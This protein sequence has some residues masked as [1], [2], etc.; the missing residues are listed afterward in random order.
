MCGFAGVLDRGA[1]PATGAEAMAR[2]LEHRGPDGDGA[3]SDGP[4]S[5]AHRRLAILDP[6]EAAHQPMTSGSLVLAYNGEI[7]NFRELASELGTRGHA[8]R[9]KGDTEVLLAAYR[10]WGPECL[11][12][13]NGMF[14]FAV[15]DGA[16]RELFLARDRF[17][18]K[19]LYWT[20]DGDRFL[21]ASEVKALL[22]AGLPRRVD[23]KALVEYFTF[24]NIFTDRTLFEGVHLLPPG[25]CL[26]LSPERMTRWRWWDL[27]F[28]SDESRAE[29]DWEADVRDVLSAAV[30]RH[31]VSDAPL[32][33]YLSG[34]M[35]SASIVALASRKMPGLDTF[36]GGFDMSSVSGLELV[37][38]ER[39]EAALV[40]S[41]AGAHRHE[42]VMHSGDMGR[43]M[44]RL[45]WN[46]EDPRAG[47]CYQNLYVADLAAR[48]VK[49]ALAGT[50]GD[51]I[52]AGY[53]WR[54]AL[55]EDAHDSATF[56]ERYFA[57]W[58][59]VVPVADH[60]AFFTPQIL[61]GAADHAPFDIYRE[62]VAPGDGYDP[63]QRALY[64]ETKTFLHAL[65]VIEDKISMSAGLEVRLPFLDQELV[66]LVSRMP[67]RFKFKNGQGKSVLRRAMRDVLPA[68]IVDKPK[69]GFTPPEGSWHRGESMAYVRDVLLDERTLGRGMILP[70]AIRTAVEEHVGGTR[71]HR[72]LIWSLLVFEW[73]NRVF[74]DRSDEPAA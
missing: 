6:S 31:L 16:R 58:N 74:I 24:Q 7:Y 11:S 48:S 60:A 9:S 18:M 62:V 35:D 33:S 5:V 68:E 49:V 63:V 41:A 59:R 13:L 21:F 56:D 25:T 3:F 54:Y 52:F 45:T 70:D 36:T 73:W 46:V 50:G 40:A 38:D 55:I 20:L 69:Q 66:S 65:L 39:A 61:D 43:V 1:E 15:W 44:P 2:M 10:E 27:E 71:N 67:S 47:T 28:D 14:A 37:Y 34:G 8:F 53:R 4:F 72:Q 32:G 22:A 57:Y 51:E 30:D 19:P 29:A 42:V 17:G 26:R 12:R 64:F 23:A